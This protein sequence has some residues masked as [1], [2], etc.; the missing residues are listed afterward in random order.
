[1][2]EKKSCENCMFMKKHNNKCYCCETIY[3][4]KCPAK[5]VCGG[6]Q[7]KNKLR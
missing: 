4:K 7:L 3:P 1:M 6:W 2:N 5:F